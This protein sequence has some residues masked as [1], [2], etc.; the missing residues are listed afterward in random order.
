GVHADH[1]RAGAEREA[2]LPDC[3]EGAGT[4]E[5][6]VGGEEG[7][8]FDDGGGGD[9]AVERIGREGGG[10]LGGGYGD[11][12]SERVN[13]EP[14]LEAVNEGVEW[15]VRDDSSSNECGGDLVP[16][17]RAECQDSRDVVPG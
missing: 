13:G 8:T 3:A 5:G 2:R 17:L 10:E 16:E 12:G 4:A 6:A 7:D 15:F 1:C 9:D 14:G 11:G